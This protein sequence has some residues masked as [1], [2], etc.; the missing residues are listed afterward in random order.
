MEFIKPNINID[1][2]GKRKIAYTVSFSMILISILSLIF[3]GG[4]KYGIDFVGGTVIQVKFPA[5]VAIS[6]I[7]SGLSEMG[8]ENSTI[9]TFG[10]ETD[11]DYLI[12]TE[13]PLQTDDNFSQK[14]KVLYSENNGRRTGYPQGGNG[15]SPG[16]QGSAGKGDVRHFLCHALYCHLYLR[17]V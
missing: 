11:H 7:K 1:F 10:K 12:R 2:V 17:T 5:A 13:A 15:R 4:P 14:I 3:H 6:D 9:Q 16:G 8:L